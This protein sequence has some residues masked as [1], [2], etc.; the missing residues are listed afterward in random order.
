M[1]FYN[2]KMSTTKMYVLSLDHRIPSND[3]VGGAFHSQSI[4]FYLVASVS[5]LAHIAK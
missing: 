4:P 1:Y 2:Q 3:T 5:S